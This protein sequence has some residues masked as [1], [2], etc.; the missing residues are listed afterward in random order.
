VK[1]RC[2]PKRILSHLNSVVQAPPRVFLWQ[3]PIEWLELRLPA[4]VEFTGFEIRS[5]HFSYE[6]AFLILP[7]ALLGPSRGKTKKA[8]T[9]LV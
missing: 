5:F 1:L 3:R 7:A 6:F 9:Q 4:A 8:E 2:G